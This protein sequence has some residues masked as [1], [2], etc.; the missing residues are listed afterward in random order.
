VKK[1]M[2]LPADVRLMNMATALLVV[3]FVLLALGSWAWWLIRHPS[4][5]LQTITVQGEVSRNNAFAFRTH[6]LPKLEGNFFTIDLAKTRQAFEAVPWVRVAVVHRDFPN[7]LRA[8]LLEHRPMALWGDEDAGTLINEQ[9]QVFE[10]NLDDADA[11]RLPRMKGP[12]AESQNVAGMYLALSPR[13]EALDMQIELLELTPRGSWRLQT[14]HGAQIELG[15]GSNTEILQRLDVFLTS[16]KQVTARYERGVSALAAA[17]LRHKDGYA[18]RLHG[19]STVD[20][21][22]KKK[23]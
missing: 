2:P 17:D 23:P 21:D 6:V 9:G 20:A 7:R 1:T 4:F 5:A 13:L 15:R 14:Q 16:L 8:V 18:L 19:V 10:A 3:V 22:N 11:E 12:G